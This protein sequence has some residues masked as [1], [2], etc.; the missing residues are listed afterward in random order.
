[1]QTELNALLRAVKQF[2]LY[3]LAAALAIGM[4]CLDVKLTGN[5]FGEYSCVQITQEIILLADIILFSMLAIKRSEIRQSSILIAGFFGCMFIR[6]LDSFF[7][8]ISPGFWLYPALA[9]TALCLLLVSFNLKQ[10]LIQLAEYTRSPSYSFMI[11]GLICILIFSR[12]FGM[13]YIWYGLDP[14]H[15]KFMLYHIKSAVEEG[16]ELFGYALCF[17][18]SFHYLKERDKKPT[19]AIHKQR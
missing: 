17:I 19:Q 18:S 2:L 6:E 9:I 5:Q 1:M 4:L 12:L 11:S 7:D 13:K 10:T 3:S 14:D 15:S 16:S 8:L